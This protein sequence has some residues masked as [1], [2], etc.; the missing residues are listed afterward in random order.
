MTVLQV[1]AWKRWRCHQ[2]KQEITRTDTS[3]T[4]RVEVDTH[5]YFRHSADIFNPGDTWLLDG[6]L[7]SDLFVFRVTSWK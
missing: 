5:R 4:L 2:C 6:E 3:S 1:A 7:I